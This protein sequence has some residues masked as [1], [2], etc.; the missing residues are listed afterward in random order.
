MWLLQNCVLTGDYAVAIDPA[1]EWATAA[2]L[3]G[4]PGRV[5]V[6]DMSS[7][8]A[9]VAGLL[10]IRRLIPDPNP[11][12][13][14]YR[15]PDGT[16]NLVM[17][18]AD[19]QRAR[20][21]RLTV[22]QDSLRQLVDTDTWADPLRRNALKDAAAECDGDLWAAIDWLDRPDEERHVDPVTGQA[23]ILNQGGCD[24]RR[25][26]AR[27]L[28][29]MAHG[30]AR[31]VFPY[32]GDDGR[33]VEPEDGLLDSQVVVI[34]MQGMQLPAPGSDRDHWDSSERAA[35]LTMRLAAYLGRRLIEVRP[36]RAR[37]ALIIDEVS[38]L[39]NWDQGSSWIASFVRH[40]RRWNTALF[41]MTQHP[42]DLKRLDPEGN[43]FASGGF[44]GATKQIEVAEM[45][46][47]IIRAAVAL[48]ATATK[49]SLVK[50][51]VRGLVKM[52]GE[53]I[54]VDWQGRCMRVRLDI[55]AFPV[56]AALTNTTPDEVERRVSIVKE[57]T[58]AIAV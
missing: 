39:A 25:R 49:L 19:R 4:A 13:V 44:V 1:G 28:T 37:K 43:T 27:D 14:K 34:T 10:A 15:T 29:A 3:V 21:E 53:F 47:R 31:V 36:R 7:D 45:S 35:A 51:P 30:P 38:W 46:L 24:E 9:T 57:A 2:K 52:P 11:G 8:D 22:S 58:D 56:L 16:T 23:T 42:D 17:L 26:L 5:S 48:A 18:D 50:D 33:V 12:D 32:R 40:L 54:W 41:L 6:V 20:A 55:E